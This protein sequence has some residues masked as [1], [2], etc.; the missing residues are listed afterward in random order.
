MPEWGGKELSYNEYWV[1]ALKKGFIATTFFN[2]SN[3]IAVDSFLRNKIHF[4]DIFFIVE[5]VSYAANAGDP[6]SIEEVFE[7]DRFA[8]KLTESE[9][10]KL[11]KKWI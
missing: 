7:Y 4:T 8:R 5:K 10:N 6:K 3:E 2:A 11:G 9:I 1:L